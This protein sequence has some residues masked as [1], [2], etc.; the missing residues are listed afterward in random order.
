MYEILI[1][2]EIVRFDIKTLWS[3]FELAVF[4]QVIVRGACASEFNRQ[5]VFF[6][7]VEEHLQ[8]FSLLRKAQLLLTFFWDE[9]KG[10]VPRKSASPVL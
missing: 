3:E 8:G 5:H 4:N 6:D 7:V 10:D 2:I 9:R 1:E